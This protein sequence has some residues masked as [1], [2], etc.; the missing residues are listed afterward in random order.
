M[1]YL[2]RDCRNKKGMHHDGH[3]A[4]RK[5]EVIYLMLPLLLYRIQKFVMVHYL[6]E[7]RENI[8]LGVFL[9]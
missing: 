7:H 4:Y 3:D 8:L 2:K 9:P 1:S 5:R 6:S